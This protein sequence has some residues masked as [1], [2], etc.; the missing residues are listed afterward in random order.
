[1]TAIFAFIL[2]ILPTTII[3]ILVLSV[4]VFAHEWGHFWTA[5]KFGLKP[6]EFGFGFPP[7]AWGIYK[8]KE[9][10]WKKVRGKTEI[11][12]ASD[13]IYSINWIPL[14]GF[15]MLGEDDDPSGDPTHFN[16]KPIW[17]RT[18]IILAGVT[19]NLV[20]AAFLFAFGF[21]IG[22]P[23]ATEGI[24]PY[25]KVSNRQI[26]V[27]DVLVDSVAGKSGFLP[28]DVIL[29]IDGR[30]FGQISE[31]QGYVNEK[32]NTELT[33][34]VK[35]KS[36]EVELKA[37]PTI[38]EET[39]AGGI[40]IGIVERGIVR[41]SIP[42]AIWKGVEYTG[43]LTKEICKAFYFLIKGLVMGDGLSEEI[44][45][46]VGI[47]TITGQAAQ[48]GFAYLLQFT[49]ILSINLAILN[50][51]PFPALDGGRVLFLLIEKIKGRPVRK[52]LE[53][54]IHN[55]GFALLMLL[56]VV[57]TVKDISRISYVF[58]DLWHSIFS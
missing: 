44:S 46:P 31:L 39:N 14:G 52:E 56:V 36:G 13:T 10:K 9:G 8:D 32:V 41:Y 4:L 43:F 2:N 15:V 50:A 28:E 22:M 21:M 17:N 34:K 3:F 54:I 26:M 35:R 40:G 5:R 29:S 19:M 30:T 58:V 51:L 16:S 37:I 55:T 1:M 7:R 11:N 33:Y 48:R 12:D 6:K 57:V 27:T 47:A 18:I 45:G 49:A 42:V 24:D 23:Q 25:A 38:L 20:L 53:A